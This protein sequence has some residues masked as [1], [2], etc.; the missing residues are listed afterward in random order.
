MVKSVRVRTTAMI[1][2]FVCWTVPA[3]S[4]QDQQDK[5][6]G[7]EKQQKQEKPAESQKQRESRAGQ[8]QQQAKH[9]QAQPR[10]QE[11]SKGREDAQRQKQQ[12]SSNKQEQQIARQQ[13]DHQRQAQQNQQDNSARQRQQARTQQD[14]QQQ[15]HQQ[16]ENSANQQIQAR[17]EQDRQRQRNRQQ[18]D[19]KPAQQR[20]PVYVRQQQAAWQGDRAHSWQTEHRT[21]QQR[22]GYNG[23]RIP[24]NRFQSYYGRDHGFRIYTL[25]V[26]YVGGHRRFR[27]GGYWFG[28]VD[29]WPEYWSDD[30]YDNDD[31]YVDYNGDGYYLYNRKYPSDRISISFYLN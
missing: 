6:K 3:F 9:Q 11:Q 15:R 2:L 13:Q 8:D 17:G 10:Q 29:P 19:I 5:P 26:R 16:R 30:W 23:Y 18:Q 21:W 12:D 28:L 4:R 27:Y 31:M 14:Q 20:T 22:G 1:F 24:D 25:P 7:P